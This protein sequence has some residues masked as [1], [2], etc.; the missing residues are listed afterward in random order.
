MG[1]NSGNPDLVCKKR[2]TSTINNAISFEFQFADWN[3]DN[4][5]H[6]Q[7]LEFDDV[8]VHIYFRNKLEYFSEAF[9]YIEFPSAVLL[10]SVLPLRYKHYQEQWYMFAFGYVLWVLRIF[11]YAAIFR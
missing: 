5:S 8:S 4:V 11:K 9:N 6:V 3:K 7:C 1:K 2:R 10:I